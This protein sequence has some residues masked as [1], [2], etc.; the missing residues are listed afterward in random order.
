MNINK[1]QVRLL[2]LED[3]QTGIIISINGGKMLTKRLADLG[4]STGTK[5]KILRK[6]PFSGPVQVEVRGSKLVLGRGLA[7]KIMVEIQ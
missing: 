4:L 2:D 5:I 7:F 6:T 3:G 1:G